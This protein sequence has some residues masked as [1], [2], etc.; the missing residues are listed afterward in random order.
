MKAIASMKHELRGKII[1]E[2]V[3]LRAKNYSYL[4]DDDT[5]VKQDKVTK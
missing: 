2:F 1:T 5:K 4:M 3:V